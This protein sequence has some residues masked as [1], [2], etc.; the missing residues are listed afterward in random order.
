M[1]KKLEYKGQ[2]GATKLS[3]C[4][5]QGSVG[6]IVGSLTRDWFHNSNSWPLSHSKASLPLKNWNIKFKIK[7]D[8]H[9]EF[10]KKLLAIYL[11][12]RTTKY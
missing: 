7:Q 12:T 3:S 2:L 5:I 6:S 1:A 9:R 11:P 4:M 10:K 8:I